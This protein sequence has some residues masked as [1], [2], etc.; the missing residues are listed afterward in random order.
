ME[1]IRKEYDSDKIPVKNTVD[2][3][4]SIHFTLGELHLYEEEIAD[5]VVEFDMAVSILYTIEPAEMTSE[6]IVLLMKAMLSIGIAY[7]KQNQN[8]RALLIYIECVKFLIASKN[9][10]INDFGL[11]TEES[12]SG[13]MYV[14][15]SSIAWN[16]DEPKLYFNISSI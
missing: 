10:N 12:V 15:P 14:Y 8:D 2:E 13:K 5:A 9:T 4:A 1:K 16:K 7:E 3:L 6:H 11:D